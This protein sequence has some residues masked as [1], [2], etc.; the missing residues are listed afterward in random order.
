MPRIRTTVLEQQAADEVTAS[1]LD[2]VSTVK[3][4]SR[5]R[6]GLVKLTNQTKSMM[7]G[8]D[9]SKAQPMH[10]VGLYIILH[11]MVYGVAPT[12][13]AQELAFAKVAARE[14]MRTKCKGKFDI[15]LEFMRWVWSRERNREQYRRDKHID[16]KVL[17]WRSILKYPEF[18]TE[19]RVGQERRNHG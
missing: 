2:L 11:K 9:W 16:G 17:G 19:Y 8:D 12:L 6:V 10:L 5:P 4:R 15:G 7:D 18:W 1:M 13:D 3:T 14:F